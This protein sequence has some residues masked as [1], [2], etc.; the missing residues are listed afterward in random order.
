MR[1][2]LKGRSYEVKKKK[3]KERMGIKLRKLAKGMVV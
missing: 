2:Q 3:K 1:N